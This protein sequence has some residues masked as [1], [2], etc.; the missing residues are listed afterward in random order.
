MN[1]QV[2]SC[3]IRQAP[4]VLDGLLYHGTR[5]EPREHTTDTSGFTELIFAICHLLGFQFAPRI[6][7]LPE[8]RLWKPDKMVR[9]K[10][11]ESVFDGAINVSLIEECWTEMLR[12]VAS[13]KS[14]KVRASLIISKLSAASRQN[15][16]FR[17]ARELGR[18]L[19]TGYIVKYVRD[20]S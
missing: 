16:L 4:Y 15:K 18:L 5:L 19:K 10:H 2:I 7:D 12:L 9:Y 3:Q 14:G 11:I 1:N 20:N 6:K 17:A 8:Q 13:I